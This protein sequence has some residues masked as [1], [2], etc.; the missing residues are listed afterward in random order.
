ML[1]CVYASNR[2][3][4][5]LTG[6]GGKGGGRGA[7]H[8]PDPRPSS[9]RHARGGAGV[10]G[11]YLGMHTLP[12]SAV[13]FLLGRA[14]EC[15]A[16]PQEAFPPAWGPRLSAE[17]NNQPTM[18]RTNVRACVRACHMSAIT[19]VAVVVVVVAAVA[20]YVLMLMMRVLRGLAT[21]VHYAF[22]Q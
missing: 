13:R 15:V 3:V 1:A 19:V 21:R 12:A 14:S 10:T 2:R 17:P 11:L 18:Q 8:Q 9:G 16:Q 20:A 5:A 4:S 6:L 7:Q 22:S